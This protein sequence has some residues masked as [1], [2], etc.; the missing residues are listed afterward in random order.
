MSSHPLKSL[1]LALPRERKQLQEAKGLAQ[2][3]GAGKMAPGVL[4]SRLALEKSLGEKRRGRAGDGHQHSSPPMEP[5]GAHSKTWA[6][7]K[8]LG[9]NSLAQSRHVCSVHVYVHCAQRAEKLGSGLVLPPQAQRGSWERVG[10]NERHRFSTM[11]SARR[12]QR[13]TAGCT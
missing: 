5:H 2:G 6:Q 13:L 8:M 3:H 9:C 4:V 7:S 10:T 1:R 11:G 12:A